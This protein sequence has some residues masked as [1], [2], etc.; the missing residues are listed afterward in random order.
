[1]GVRIFVTGFPGSGKSSLVAEIIKELG[2]K[3]GGIV[4]PEIRESGVR[5]G[6]RIVDLASGKEGILSRVGLPG[7]RIGRYGVNLRDIEEIGTEAI[8]NALEDPG[9]RLVVM[10]EVGAMEMISGKFRGIVEDA[11]SSDK[12]CL[13]V[14]HRSFVDKYKG[15]GRIFFLDRRNRE[16]VK[17][18]I[19]EI[20]GRTEDRRLWTL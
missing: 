2:V 3:S 1:M 20:L 15:R 11:L 7:P 6:F 4:T 8:K 14:L 16:K 17:K 9:T 10:D 19:L 5:K 18:D 12:D 13:I